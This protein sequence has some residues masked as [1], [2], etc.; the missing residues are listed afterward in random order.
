MSKSPKY[1]A[2]SNS[3]A[4]ELRALLELPRLAVR[5][6]WLLKLPRGSATVVAIPGFG[7]NDLFTLPL[8]TAL[9]GLGHRTFG[10]GFGINRAEVEQMLDPVVAMV[11]ER[12]EQTGQPAALIGWSNG[13]I[14]A[15]EVARERPEL[16]TR[17]LTYGTPIHGGPKY[18]RGAPL[19]DPEELDR[20]EAVV[21]ERNEIPI[22]RPITAFWSRGDAIVDWRACIDDF[23]PDVENI[24]VRSSHAGMGIDPDIWSGIAR[25]L[26]D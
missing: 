5:A 12:V 26:V 14:F 4:R 13:G 1:A 24:E 17:V 23:S 18:T 9:S 10:W 19:Y 22:M 3:R 7:T 25:R 15:R 20:I 6:P 16:V 21:A 8:R 11:E 2:P